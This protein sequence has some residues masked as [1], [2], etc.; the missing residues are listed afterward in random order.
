MEMQS[1]LR[2]WLGNHYD[3]FKKKMREKE[4][5]EKSKINSK[6]DI[7]LEQTLD[8]DFLGEDFN[9]TGTNMG[10]E[11]QVLEN[12][13]EDNFKDDIMEDI[14]QGMS[15]CID[16]MD[17]MD[18]LQLEEKPKS[19]ELKRLKKKTEVENAPVEKPIEFQP[20]SPIQLEIEMGS[21]G[22]EEPKDVPTKR[23]KK[24]RK[25]KRE[26]KSKKEKKHKK[27]KKS[28]KEKKH[29]RKRSDGDVMKLFDNE[30]THGKCSEDEES[31][32][33]IEV[34]EDE[35]E[36]C[37]NCHK[38]D[39]NSVCKECD[40]Q[41]CT[42]CAEKHKTETKH[43]IEE[44]MS[45][46]F[47]VSDN[48]DLSED[49]SI[50]APRRK[51]ADE[52]RYEDE[53]EVAEFF[54]NIVKKNKSRR[55]QESSQSH[56]PA[57][58]LA[59]S[60]QA[61][62]KRQTSL[63][64]TINALKSSSDKMDEL[65]KMKLFEI[66]KSKEIDAKL[67]NIS[68]ST[69]KIKYEPI[70]KQFIGKITDGTFQFLIQFIFAIAYNTI[71]TESDERLLLRMVSDDLTVTYSRS[72]KT[73]I[74]DFYKKI[75]LF[76]KSNDIAHYENMMDIRKF[77]DGETKASNPQKFLI[78]RIASAW[79]IKF[80]EYVVP[81]SGFKCII[82]GEDIQVGESVFLVEIYA[83]F[84][85]SAGQSKREVT[86]WL[87]KKHPSSPPLYLETILAIWNF[88]N[89]GSLIKHKVKTWKADKFPGLSSDQKTLHEM[90]F[91]MLN[92]FVEDFDFISET[93]QHY[94]MLKSL[95]KSLCGNKKQ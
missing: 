68:A 77:N 9:M 22:N 6:N 86:Y 92:R 16:L 54:G 84:I 81:E 37:E 21:P 50:P 35:I 1:D 67:M 32:D 90:V 94:L 73:K 52:L 42:E 76:I 64:G 88:R 72:L 40:L 79:E 4:L 49:Q 39:P 74:E 75:D 46:G 18:D 20:D 17:D 31:V 13:Q 5:L 27:E 26:K 19:N 82:S 89:F 7:V 51:T 11:Q 25:E 14:A 80:E 61:P 95:V 33:D 28:K 62:K 44:A 55:D 41:L 2:L 12:I 60:S 69:I 66:N 10:Q 24:E 45:K 3:D 53:K 30:A 29:K 71:S 15:E 83:I 36:D 59:P 48:S 8:L 34:S 47:I 93:I 91:P 56:I 85:I 78:G 57:L 70:R 63:I 23:S 43:T 65:T 38:G 87:V 58:E